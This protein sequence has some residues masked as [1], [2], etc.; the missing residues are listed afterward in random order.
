MTNLN[1]SLVSI[2]TVVYNNVKGIKET[3]QS[4]IN[5]TYKNIEFIIIDGKSNDGTLDVINKYKDYNSPRI[6][7]NKYR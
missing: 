7:D 3:I 5:Q 4:V 2:I 6:L 1:Y